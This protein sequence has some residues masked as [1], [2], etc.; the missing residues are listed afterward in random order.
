[1]PEYTRRVVIEIA[2]MKRIPVYQM[3][4][5]MYTHNYK[6]KPVLLQ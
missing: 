6:L 1:M 4:S 5:A 2:K 3:K